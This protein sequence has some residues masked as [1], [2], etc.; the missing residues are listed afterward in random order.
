MQ[1]NVRGGS[2]GMSNNWVEKRKTV[3]IFS[4]RKTKLRLQFLLYSPNYCLLFTGVRR[5]LNLSAGR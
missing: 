4:L 1:F 5:T 2:R 3:I